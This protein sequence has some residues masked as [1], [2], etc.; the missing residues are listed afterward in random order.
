MG[1]S[2]GSQSHGLLSPQSRLVTWGGMCA[3]PG[4]GLLLLADTPDPGGWS[5]GL[6]GHQHLDSLLCV[7]VEAFSLPGI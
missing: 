4:R 6:S 7:S 5:A 3:G 1:A 2:Q